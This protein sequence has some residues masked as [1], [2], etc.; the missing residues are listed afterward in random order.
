MQQPAGSTGPRDVVS[1][2]DLDGV[3]GEP[4]D[5]IGTIPAQARRAAQQLRRTLPRPRR[6]LRH[7]WTSHCVRPGPGAITERRS[8]ALSHELAYGA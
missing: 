4:G 5:E 3:L 2:R 7:H 6:R 1:S 8:V